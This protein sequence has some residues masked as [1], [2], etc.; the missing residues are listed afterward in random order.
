VLDTRPR[1]LSPEGR[2]ALRILA[3]QVAAQLELRRRRREADGSGEKLLLE[4]SGL[5]DA[6]AGASDG[7]EKPFDE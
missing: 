1:D 7:G 2:E 5:S 4:V 6:D 3:A